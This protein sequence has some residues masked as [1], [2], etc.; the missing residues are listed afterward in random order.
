MSTTIT[1][2][3]MDGPSGSRRLEL[4]DLNRIL[5]IEDAVISPDGSQVAYTLRHSILSDTENRHASS[6]W[7]VSTSGDSAPRQITIGTHRDG[8]PRW[9]P[10]GRRLLF[11]SDR[12]GSDTNQLF[13]LHLDGGEAQCLTS[14]SRGVYAPVVSPD[15]S[16]VALLSSQDNGMTDAEMRAPGGTIRRIRRLSYRTDEMGYVDERDM[17]LWL[18]DLP[19]DGGTVSDPQRLTWGEGGVA[20]AAWS[21]DGTQIAFAANRENEAGFD[22]QLYTIDVQRAGQ[23]PVDGQDGARRISSSV[24]GAHGPV[25]APD[26]G[27]VA[28]VGQRADARAGANAEIFLADPVADEPQRTISL[29][30]DRSPGTASYS[31]TWSAREHTP[32]SWSDV[33]GGGIQFTGSDEGRVGIYRIDPGSCDVT[34]VRSADES[35]AFPTQATDGRMAWVAATFT[36]P[37]DI[38]TSAADGSDVRRLTEVNAEVLGDVTLQQ[39]EHQPFTAFDG[40]FEVDSWL[41]RPVGYD[42]ATGTT[43]PLVQIIHGGPHSIFGH[44]FF[45]DMQLW[46]ACGYNVLFMNPRATQG[47]GESFATGNIGDWGGA[48]WKEQEQALD[49][50]IASGG[51]DPERLAVTGL[52][53]GG[54]MTNWIVGQTNRYR[55]GI[56]ENGICNLVSFAGTSDIGWYWLEPEM[57]QPLWGNLD[58]YMRHSPL[59]F[60][61]QMQTPM[62][63]LQAE[64]DFRCPI[65]QGEQFYTALR[66]RGIDAEMI[67]FPGERH[68]QLSN[69]KPRTRLVRREATLEWL[70]RYLDA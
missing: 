17:H 30:W 45:F 58:W 60:I 31:D 57:E 49:N 8:S 19:D 43:H 29:A 14:L 37:C 66:S 26:G 7:L 62:L 50:A 46:A 55:V 15:G 12:D 2:P 47:Y 41:I 33:N 40:Q 61:E 35:I 24:R 39:P 51:V 22:A 64:T 63:L 44:T 16:R 27:T 67:R 36:N 9:L 6:I 4:A 38:Y 53:Y 52:S 1:T 11:T 34:S 59:W 56:S 5:V 25:W 68:G 32:L 23:P 48:D 28:F 20:T 13:L 21:P 69:G 18:L 65:E 54:F 70:A 10:C 3:R 42:A